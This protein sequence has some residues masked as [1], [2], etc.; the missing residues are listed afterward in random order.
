[1]VLTGST[2]EMALGA[3]LAEAAESRDLGSVPAICLGLLGDGSGG[4]AAL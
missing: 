1:M 3:A 2:A 4:D